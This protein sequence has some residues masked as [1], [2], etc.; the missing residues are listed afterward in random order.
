MAFGL[1]PKYSKELALDNLSIKEFLIISIEAAKKIGWDVGIISETGFVAYTKF[2]M[3]SW[4]EEIKVKIENDKA[5]LKSECTGS[6]MMDLGKNKKNIDNFISTINELKITISKEELT[7]KYEDIQSQFIASDHIDFT[8]PKPTTKEKLNGFFSIFKPTEGYFITPILIN[9]N[10]LIFILM[11]GFGVNF[12]LPSNESLI[13][14]GAN[15]KPL[16]LEGEWWRLMTCCFLHIGI[17]HLLLNMYAL[18]Y[19]G[20]LLEPYLGKARFLTAYLLTGLTASLTSL[21]WHDLTISAG[22]SGAIFGMY[23]VFLAMLT[24]NLIEKSARKALL[25][26]IAVFVLYNLLN[27]LKGGIDNAAHIGGL[28]GGL[29]VGYGLLRSLKQPDNTSLKYVTIGVLSVFIISISVVIYAKTP[30]DIGQYEERI[31]EFVIAEE[32]ALSI[33]N[34]PDNTPNT[35]LLEE[36]KEKG[37]LN[38]NKNIKLIIE[39][40]KLNLPE[41]IRMRDIKLVN[42]CNTR[43]KS[44]NML[45]KAISE[46]TDNYKDSLEIYNKEIEVIIKSLSE[47]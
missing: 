32:Q 21:W 13:T 37:I 4:S 31:K 14:W 18:V 46:N 1:S 33:Y 26:S 38:W 17:L 6:Q 42:Y 45:Y 40:E 39:L 23:G 34:L 19:I 36:I 9:I 28:I 7:Q 41:T 47:N 20:L 5:I 44:Y 25:T 22:A 15:F 11:V 43:I 8:N 12:M 30:N 35:L 29:V 24:T 10:I 16:T 2:S 3:S 27:G